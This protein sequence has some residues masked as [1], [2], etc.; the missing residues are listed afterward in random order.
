MDQLEIVVRRV[1][2]KDRE[3]RRLCIAKSV[4]A[5]EHALILDQ[6]VNKE[7]HGMYSFELYRPMPIEL[8]SGFIEE[9]LV[10]GGVT[11]I[12]VYLRHW[13][14]LPGRTATR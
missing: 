13:L 2:R 8:A 9:R 3:I 10:S 11:E 6:Q 12:M 14:A 5:V 1:S 4:D 7:G